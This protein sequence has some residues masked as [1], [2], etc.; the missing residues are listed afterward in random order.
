M[1]C[2]CS[3][4]ALDVTTSP[5]TLYICL[6]LPITQSADAYSDAGDL[7]PD[8]THNSSTQ[9]LSGAAGEATSFQT[10]MTNIISSLNII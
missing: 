2:C 7:L 10:S 3:Q 9:T 6:T 4:P 8:L 5:V 1:R